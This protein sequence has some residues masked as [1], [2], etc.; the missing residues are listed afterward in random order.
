MAVTTYQGKHLIGKLTVSKTESLYLMTEHD[1]MEAGMGL[2]KELGVLHI[3]L[4]ATGS[5][6]VP[7]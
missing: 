5:I 6:Y 1:G 2:E 7:H 4:Q 3:D